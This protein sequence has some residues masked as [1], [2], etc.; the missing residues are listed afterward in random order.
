MIYDLVII[1]AGPSGLALA[2]CCS[3]IPN[4][5]ILVIERESQIGGCHR[6]NR[7]KHN[8]EKLFTEH[9]PRIYSSS[10]KNFNY[11]LYEM[12]TSLKEL[13]TPYK[14]QILNMSDIILTP[15]LSEIFKIIL[16]FIFL[17]LNNNYGRNINMASYMS[18]NK[19]SKKTIDLVDRLCRLSDGG[20]IHKYNLN[21]FLQLINQQGL[22]TIYQPKNPTDKK[23]FIIW[24]KYLEKK[25]VHF[26]LNSEIK[27]I[28]INDNKI[29]SCDINSDTIHSITGNKYIFAI[30]PKNLLELFQ[31]SDN[32][33]LQNSY[34]N[35]NIFKKWVEDSDYIEYISIVYHWDI[36]LDLPKLFAFSKSSSWGIIFIV[37][38]DYINFDESQSKTVISTAITI[39]DKKGKNNKTA[40]ECKDKDEIIDEVYNQLKDSFPNLPKPSIALI[41]PNNF[42]DNEEK[43]W[44]SKDTAFIA[45]YNTPYIHFQSKIIDNLY[46]LG[47]Q[48]GKSHYSFTSL[49]SA[50]S[51]S[52]YLSGL[53]YPELKEKY[54]IIKLTTVRDVLYYIIIFIIILLIILNILYVYN[55]R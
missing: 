33:L 43:E 19:F 35:F 54:K 10:Y 28:K 9:G 26:M 7:V 51:N 18:D 6:V 15:N 32:N 24:K 23:L 53:L 11:L 29:I 8:N 45:A 2:H 4:I 30:P 12:N 47:T 31:K 42:Y 34:G 36:K 3:N 55:N 22:Y 21:K 13:Y 41:T 5:K 48:N 52:M 1:G 46:T 16:S 44:E 38:T 20:D 25:G 50:V 14:F 40:N 17:L 49:E 27:N 37:L 39:V